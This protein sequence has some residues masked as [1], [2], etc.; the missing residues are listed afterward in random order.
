MKRAWWSVALCCAGLALGARAGAQ[1]PGGLPEGQAANAAAASFLNADKAREVL[2]EYT[3]SAPESAYAGKD[4]KTLAAVRLG[5]CAGQPQ[6]P[7][8]AG[9]VS[10]A[11]A[12]AA[13]R[14][15]AADYAALTSAAS[16]IAR[17]PGAALELINQYYSGCN[18]HGCPAA[19]TFCFGEACFDTKTLA[20][21]DFA[22]TMSFMEAAR[23]AGV[24]LDPDTI[25]V[26][27]G[28]GDAC[29]VGA[30]SNCCR[31]DAKG[32][33]MSNGGLFTVGTM[34]VFDALMDST[35]R[36]F[37]YDGI[38]SLLTADSF[39]GT[40]TS[41]GVTLSMN[42][43]A[44]P[45]GTVTISSGS[46]WAVAFNP[47]SLAITVGIQ[48]VTNLLS[49]SKAEGMM[50][51]REGAHLCHS[52]GSYCS[53]CLLRKPFGGGCLICDQHATGK[54]CF[55][56]VLARLINEQGRSQLGMD[57]GRADHLRCDGFT[58]AQLQ[59]LDFSAMDLSEFYS[60]LA[61]KVPDAAHLIEQ[62]KSSA[63]KCYYGGGK[64]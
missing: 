12:A 4:L 55:N 46:G 9:Q 54:C 42:G 57:W 26:F 2:P 48:V 22:Q 56:S 32:G 28:Q 19:G 5:Q 1:T 50:A 23:E 21:P 40:F 53:H 15:P 37:L 10:A 47:W 41:F 24:Y 25:Q 7:V 29:R 16:A 44:L 39:G 35:N 64:C 62:A 52:V 13:P 63:P 8:C 20:D 27:G 11:T 45:A 14:V 31:S 58:V 38:K 6:D 43:V 49:C 36:H 34:L 61:P 17:N 30:L 18:S 51:L 60:S 33:G 3:S 59:R